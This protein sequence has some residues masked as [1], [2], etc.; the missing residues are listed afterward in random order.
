[1]QRFNEQTFLEWRGS[2]LTK[3]FLRY[4]KDNQST[5]A[6]QWASGVE[7]HPAQQTKAQI[8]G[9]LGSLEWADYKNFY[10]LD[11]GAPGDP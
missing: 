6:K 2:P 9:E 8:L 5:L 10:G 7:L 11:D 4:L 3:V 1:M